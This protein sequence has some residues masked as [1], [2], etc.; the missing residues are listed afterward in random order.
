MCRM[1]LV[2]VE[3]PRGTMLTTSCT[4]K[5][6]E[7]MVV[8]TQSETVTKAQEGVL[9]FLL[10]N[11]PLDCPVCDR[12]GECP[13]QDQALAY[14]PGESRFVEEKRHYLKPV[15]ISDLV[16][17][18]RERCI[19]C[20]RCTRFS[21]EISGDPLI[22]FAGRGSASRIVTFPDEPFTSYFSGNTV[23]ICPVGA[24]TAA[25]YR[26]RARPWDLQAVE[27]TC[28]MCAVGCRA[29]VQS[30]G[31]E[32][33]RI[34]GVDSD[35]TNHGWLCDKG[36]FGFEYLAAP[37]RIRTPLMRNDA[38]ELVAASWAD[39]LT[40]VAERLPTD[41]TAAGL[42]G[43]HGTNEEA[44]AFAKFMRTVARSPHIDATVGDSLTS[45][46][47][48]GAQP[49]AT[50]GD[51]DRAATVLVWGPDLKEELPVLYL[52]VRRAVTEMGA[53][54]VVVSPRRTGLDKVATHALRYRP[55]G[56]M[57][58]LQRL[59]SGAAAAG[60]FAQGPVVALIGRTGLGE[61]PAVS[62][63]AASWA[64]D[65]PGARILPLVRR[66]NT[67]GALDMGVAPDLLPGRV[68]VG[69]TAAAA[70]LRAVWGE[71]A[72]D[73]GHGAGEILEGLATGD[74]GALILVGADPVRDHP[75]PAKARRA[76]AAAG[77]VVAFDLFISDSSAMADVVLPVAAFGESEGTVT[78]LEGRV[79]KVHRV[80]TSPGAAR[81]TW[82]VLED[83]SRR[84]DSSIGATSAEVLAK[85]IAAVAPAYCNLTWDA[86]EWGEGRE[87]IVVPTPQGSQPLVY[88]P[89][90]D[91]GD[92]STDGMAL[93][94]ARVLYDDGVLVTHSPSLSRLRRQPAA[95]LHPDDAARI[96]VTAG[97]EVRVAN[98]AGSVRLP[99]AVDASL[100]PGT[101]YV[102]YNLDA[103]AH[104]AASP[105][106][107]VEVAG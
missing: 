98:T 32:V 47:T 61:E 93:H 86:L 90:P 23:Q 85:E 67:V 34:N 55:G 42:G 52:R 10:I 45:L 92:I 38:G 31:N 95:Y 56:A 29:S 48:V 106:V 100:A 84:L 5:V 16:L 1:C 41:G 13:L 64:V 102:P 71:F 104:F 17:L 46:F 39:A 36:R 83:L 2:E 12:G 30:T 76:I 24:L 11:H 68:A 33:V 21:E 4:T 82:S 25:P 79:Q 54:L 6:A 96:G 87:G 7:D 89:G 73:R 60:A 99:V 78:N 53:E 43:A 20:A 49:R 75:N 103:T 26:F 107:S 81:S 62:E 44:Y 40:R 51:L 66:A 101:V 72:D 15:E 97:T 74:M 22:E 65:L 91:P 18:D 88:V 57:A 69:D 77:F 58:M 8:H 94:L 19:L 37:Q 14:G 3:G 63:A 9:E 59:R 50:Y 27:S 35:A 80:T 70:D 105:V 28:T